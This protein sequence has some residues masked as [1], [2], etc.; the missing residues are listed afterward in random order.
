[1]GKAAILHKP[2]PVAFG[3]TRSLR[4]QPELAGASIKTCAIVILMVWKDNLNI[5]IH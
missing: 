2:E 4:S 1:M 5:V 3:K